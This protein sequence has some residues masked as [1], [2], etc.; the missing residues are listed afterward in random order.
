MNKKRTLPEYTAV[1]R[2]LGRAG[3]K[4]Q[5]LLNSLMSQSHPPK[6]IVVYLAEGYEKPSETVGIE[7]I[8]YVKKGMVAQRALEYK[9]VE[10][11]WILFLDDDIYIE[12][13]G[14]EKMLSDTILADADVCAFDA[15]PHHKL[16]FFKKVAMAFLL[17][18]V[19][20]LRFKNYGY[21]VNFLGTDC[22]NPFPRKDWSWS[23]TNSGGAF[24]CKKHN[25]L[26]I[27]FEEDLW[28][29]TV[30]VAAFD[31][32][33]M[34]FKMHLKGLKIITHY[35]SGFA[36]LDARTSAPSSDKIEQLRKCEYSTAFTTTVF[37]KRYLLPSLNKWEKILRKPLKFYMNIVFY[38]FCATKKIKKLDFPN[39]RKKGKQEAY[40]YLDFSK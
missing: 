16:K 20:R 2:T 28:L 34:F 27:N 22:Y 12:S 26:K 17:S 35:K 11:E 1:I 7:E 18:S 15:F 6:K 29:D 38:F 13:W 40:K 10:T 21:R 39:E 8:V 32:K 37:E 33:I 25:F 24:I 30:P 3:E 23:T 14:V 36:H 9:E 31:D 5:I 19:P 4:Y